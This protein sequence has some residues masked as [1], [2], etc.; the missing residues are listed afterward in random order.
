MIPKNQEE[1][2]SN[3]LRYLKQFEDDLNHKVVFLFDADRTL[4]EEDTSRLFNELS[5]VDLSSIK[6]GFKKFGYTYPAFLANAEI[7]NEINFEEYIKNCR[8]IAKR[9]S[10]YN[11]VKELMKEIS[12]F[13]EIWIIT[14]GLKELWEEIFKLNNIEGCRFIGGIRK[15]FS[16]FIIGKK[17]KGIICDFLRKQNKTV[18]AFGDSDVDSEMMQKADHSIIVVNHRNNW[19]LIENLGNH[20]S[21]FQI[22]FK[23]YFH[24]N[25]IRTTFREIAG[26]LSNE[27]LLIEK[28]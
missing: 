15:E 20:K 5:N 4:C 9:I 12:Y 25:I 24:P 7:Y 13:A 1:N 2:I 10:L 28:D 6:K 23:E 11:G 3:L 26:L 17:E 22:S 27:N 16:N 18:I 14:A 21:L 19:D 8:I